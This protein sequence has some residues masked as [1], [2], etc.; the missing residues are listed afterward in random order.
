MILCMNCGLPAEDWHC[1]MTES[2]VDWSGCWFGM[3]PSRFRTSLLATA[4]IYEYLYHF[5]HYGVSLVHVAMH[6]AVYSAL[7]LFGPSLL[8][9]SP[10]ACAVFRYL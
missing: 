3:S 5:W 10:S 8:R 7:E 2:S 1:I 4:I 9:L 6:Y